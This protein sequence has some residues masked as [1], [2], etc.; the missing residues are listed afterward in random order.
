VASEAWLSQLRLVDRFA[1]ELA[2]RPPRGTTLHVTADHGMVDVPESARVDVDA[3]PLL[4]DGV[5]VLAGEPRARH[6]HC[7][8]GAVDDVLAAWQSEL[9]DRMWVGLGAEALSAGLLGPRVSD[10]TRSRVGDV[11]AIATS[12]VAIVQPHAE[13]LLTNLVRHHGALTPDELF[14]SLLTHLR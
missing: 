1:E 7:L 4:T 13:P 12:D 11:L 2:S 5:R 10:V 3:V 14:V 6:V 9:G 8:P